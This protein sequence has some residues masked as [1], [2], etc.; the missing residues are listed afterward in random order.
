MDNTAYIVAAY[1]SPVGKAPR[2]TLKDLRSDDLAKQVIQRLLSTQPYEPAAID[3]LIVGCA[4]PE[5]EQGMQMG[6]LIGLLSLPVSVPGMLLNRYC[7]SG[8]EAVHVAATRVIAGTADLVIAGGT[9][10]MSRVPMMG[11]NPA[12]NPALIQA[13]SDYFLNM[14]LT[15]EEVALSYGITREQA[16]A[17]AFASHQKAL[18]A[19]EAGAFTT[20]TVPITYT[21]AYVEAGQPI[22]QERTLQFDEG[23]RQDTSLERLAVLKPAFRHKGTVTAGNS[24]QMSDGAAFLVVA[25]GRAVQRYNLTP[26]ARF[27]AYAA[28]GVSPRVM[29]IGPVEA[30]PR[31]LKQANLRLQDLDHIEINEAFAAQVLAVANTLEIDPTK[32]NPQGGAIALG[33]PLG[34]TG[35]KLLTQVIYSLRAN[36][37]R[38]GMV[39]A[40]V[41][42]G[43]GVALIVE[44]L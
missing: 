18:A 34:C 36:Q 21:A 31:A 5:A 26:L 41:G 4:V 9:E 23:P 1:R 27:C 6:R 17:F 20:Q 28:V 38:Y 22:S 25:S 24:S 35:A 44:A 7:G 33:H 37:Q 32:L 3:D 13:H 11:H 29:G 14:G 10:S 19:L 42:G 15:A 40:C 43:Q 12:P 30:I 2:G 16:D 8:V 39:S